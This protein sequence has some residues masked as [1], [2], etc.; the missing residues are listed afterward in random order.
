MYIYLIKIAVNVYKNTIGSYPFCGCCRGGNVCG[1]VFSIAA[2]Y[3]WFSP[4]NYSLRSIFVRENKLS[5][6]SQEPFRVKKGPP[7]DVVEYN[8][9]RRGLSFQFFKAE[10]RVNVGM[11]SMTTGPR[12]FSCS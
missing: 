8:V 2:D 12:G 5:L 4:L 6:G 10:H 7:V 1:S 9:G 11:F 3:T